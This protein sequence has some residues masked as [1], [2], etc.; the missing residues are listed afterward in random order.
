MKQ[1]VRDIRNEI[2]G[3]TTICVSNGC[4]LLNSFDMNEKY[5]KHEK[6]KKNQDNTLSGTP[7]DEGRYDVPL[8]HKDEQ[9][10]EGIFQAFQRGIKAFVQ[11]YAKQHPQNPVK[12]VRVVW[13][14]NRLK[15]QVEQF[16]KV[17]GYERWNFADAYDFQDAERVQFILYDREKRKKKYKQ[18]KPQREGTVAPLETCQISR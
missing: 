17:A 9:K 4:V 14:H 11:E 16:E 18:E 1:Q 5:R 12:Q 3:M 6:I 8:E 15:R 13:K 10:R 7:E 2:I